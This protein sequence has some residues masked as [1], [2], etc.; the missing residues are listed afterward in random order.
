M[1]HPA[2]A[3]RWGSGER[4]GKRA[5]V[6]SGAA[7]LMRCGQAL[8]RRTLRW[9]GGLESTGRLLALPMLVWA[10]DRWRLG[11]ALA[12]AQG[13]AWVISLLPP[14]PR[15]PQHSKTP[16]RRGWIALPRAK[17]HLATPFREFVIGRNFLR[18]GDDPRSGVI[19]ERNGELVRELRAEGK[20]F[21]LATGHFS[22]KASLALYSRE[23]TPGRITTV[24]ANLPNRPWDPGGIW[25]RVNFGQMLRILERC[26]PDGELARLGNRIELKSLIRKLR[27]PGSIALIAADAPWVDFQSNSLVRSFAGSGMRA[28]STGVARLSRL[29]GC[30]IVVCIPFLDESG[31]VIIDWRCIIRS[32]RDCSELEDRRIT[33]LVLDEIEEAAGARPNQYVID[34]LR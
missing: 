4:V 2:C 27:A 32:E 20:S 31:A 29:T 25:R 26:R 28:Y 7:F 30:P 1:E 22:R 24:V 8:Q 17:A 33:N 23:I 11:P 14:Y 19:R 15:E 5:L 18:G 16:C 10:G 21:I 9:L 12:L 3:N 6:Q 13:L 34:L